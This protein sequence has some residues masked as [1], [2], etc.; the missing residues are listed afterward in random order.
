[1]H[2]GMTGTLQVQFR[3]SQLS[4]SGLSQILFLPDKRRQDD[5]LPITTEQKRLPGMA[6]SIHE[7]ISEPCSAQACTHQE[8]VYFAH[9]G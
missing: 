7:G 1:M 5:Y 2:F 6:A 4:N 8:S 9:T 3:Y